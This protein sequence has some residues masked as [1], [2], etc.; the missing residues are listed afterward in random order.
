MFMK[1]IIKSENCLSFLPSFVMKPIHFS[2]TH[3]IVIFV[4][5]LS[6]SNPFLDCLTQLIFKIVFTFISLFLKKIK[7]TII[8]NFNLFLQHGQEKGSNRLMDRYMYYSSTWCLYIDIYTN[9]QILYN[10]IR[11]LF[12]HL[13]EL[14]QKRMRIPFKVFAVSDKTQNQSKNW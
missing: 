3:L 11:L 8:F 13:L 4:P 10:S 6:R 14:L 9:I 12:G 2:P 1:R 5:S 7:E